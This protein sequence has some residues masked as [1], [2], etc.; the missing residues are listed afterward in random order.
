MSINRCSDQ[1][2][3]TLEDFYIELTAISTNNFI[4]VGKRMLVMVGLI[5]EKFKET[6]LWGLTS[7]ARLVILNEDKW[8]SYWYVIV[9]SIGMEDYYIEYLLPQKQQPWEN[10]TVR[11]Q[12]RNLDEA[13]NYLLIAMERSQGWDGNEEL[14]RLM[15]KYD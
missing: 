14:K 8:D 6:Q 4:D 13:F 1:R 10:A 9:S 5:N 12:A 7:H 3:Q 2:S 15:H 11:G